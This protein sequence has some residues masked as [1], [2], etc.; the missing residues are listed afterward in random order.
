LL[1]GKKIPSIEGSVFNLIDE[2]VG[3]PSLKLAARRKIMLAIEGP[4]FSF[5]HEKSQMAITRG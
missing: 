1:Q 5:M 3:R 2:K 4:S